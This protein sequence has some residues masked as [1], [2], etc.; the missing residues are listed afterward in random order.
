MLKPINVDNEIRKELSNK[1]NPNLI[2]EKP[3][4]G[5]K[6]QNPKTG[7]WEEPTLS[8]ISANTCIDIL[9]KI[10]GH[11]WSMKIIDH[12]MEPGY[13]QIVKQK[14]D[15]KT[16]ELVWPK[17]TNPPL[18]S[19]K[20]DA[21]GNKFIEL[22]QGP[23]AWCIVELTVKLKDENG[24]VYEI[25]KSAFGSQSITGGQSTQSQ[26]GYKGAQSD[27]LKKAATLLG[28]A[29][30]LY[31]DENEEEV[32]DEIYESMTPIVWT[33]EVIEQN[34]DLWNRYTKIK[35]EYG[36]TDEDT[37]YFVEQVTDRYTDNIYKMPIEYMQSLFDAIENYEEGE[38]E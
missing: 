32:F 4:G 18:N 20:T 15:F 36:W 3:A 19:I 23:S 24:E 6:R 34:K 10:F 13:K 29:L 30:E 27:A 26:N 8:Y 37:A 22:E 5:P 16:N 33:D 35:E 2:K 31:R 14:K 1:L 7:K 9:N 28:I 38:D 11:N 12:W 21:A 25:T 17:G